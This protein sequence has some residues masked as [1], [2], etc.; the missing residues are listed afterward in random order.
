MSDVSGGAGWW[1]ASDG[2]WYP[3]E[4][5]ASPPPAPPPP[6]PP[7]LFAPQLMHADGPTGASPSGPASSAGTNPPM[8]PDASP[9]VPQA[10]ASLPY[11]YGYPPSYPTAHAV[12]ARTSPMAVW[13]LVLVI[14]LGAVGSLVGVPLAFVARSKIRKSGGAL[15]GSGLALAALIVGFAW[16]G[17]FVLAIAIPTFLGVTHTGPT[18][19]ALGESVQGQIAGSAP[20]D[21]HD[22]RVADVVCEGPGQWT[23]GSTFTC[24]AYSEPSG[25]L[26]EEAVGSYYGTVQASSGGNFRWFGRYVPSG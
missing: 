2:Q 8:Y 23:S 7:P 10:P 13:A 14:L 11:P 3:P 16:L 18:Q 26:P 12:T 21:F 15:K 5:A 22:P 1:L 17:L 20:D 4:S 9:W 6:A 19:Q 24:I 25:G